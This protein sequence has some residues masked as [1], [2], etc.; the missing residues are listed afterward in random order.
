MRISNVGDQRT[1]QV[2]EKGTK[3]TSEKSAERPASSAVAKE[4][5]GTQSGV[6][7]RLGDVA[8]AVREAASRPNAPDSGRVAEILALI[9]SGKYK[10]DFER[11]AD[12]MLEEEIP[13]GKKQR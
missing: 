6:L 13:R 12:K 9:A 7:V 2:T 11:L 1:T 4:E 3:A 10:I 5:T 8:A